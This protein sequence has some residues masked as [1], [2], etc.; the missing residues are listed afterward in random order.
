[1][2]IIAFIET[3]PGEMQLVKGY[4]RNLNLTQDTS[5]VIQVY[6]SQHPINLPGSTEIDMTIVPQEHILFQAVDDF[7][8]MW[9]VK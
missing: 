9:E 3:R 5:H 2:R 7:E 1:M 8:E 6:G 4:L